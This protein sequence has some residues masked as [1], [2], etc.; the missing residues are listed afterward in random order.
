[1]HALSNVSRQPCFY[2]DHP[3]ATLGPSPNNMKSTSYANTES[4]CGSVVS[5][6]LFCG[7]RWHGNPDTE[8][9]TFQ[10]YNRWSAR[11]I[12]F[13]F[14]LRT[15][16]HHLSF[17]LVLPQLLYVSDTRSFTSENGFLTCS[18]SSSFSVRLSQ[19]VTVSSSPSPFLHSL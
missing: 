1:M 11:S 18:I 13:F 14:L 7:L 15:T 3:I 8:Q 6:S 19:A 16:L 17:S 12:V 10:A 9:H 4:R 2:H 5:S